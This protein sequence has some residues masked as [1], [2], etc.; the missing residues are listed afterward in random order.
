M[1]M[2]Q[3]AKDVVQLGASLEISDSNFMPQTLEELATLA[4]ASGA[5]LTIG[6]TLMPDTMKK[7]AAIA[8]GQITFRV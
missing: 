6:L 1:I 2:P 8:P 4:K 7:L 5:Q 3:T